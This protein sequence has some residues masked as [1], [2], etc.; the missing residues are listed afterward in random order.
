ANLVLPVDHVV[1]GVVAGVAL[2]AN[3]RLQLDRAAGD[4]ELQRLRLALAVD[5]ELHVGAGLAD[6]LLDGLLGG[7]ALGGD[8]LLPR[9]RVALVVH[10]ADDVGDDVAGVDFGL[11]GG[12]APERWD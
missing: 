12:A 6:D 2:D 11:V 8:Y 5:A 10:G 3:D 9:Q 7:H 1:P 4:G